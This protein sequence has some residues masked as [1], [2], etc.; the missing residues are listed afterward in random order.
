MITR[1]RILF[2]GAALGVLG[3]PALRAFVEA[4]S[5]ASPGD[6]AILN[7]A[8][9]LERAAVKAYTDAAGTGLLSA[10]VGTV[11]EGFKRD[12]EAHLGALMAAVQAA[13]AAPSTKAANLPYPPLKTEK[14]ILK[15]ARSVEE[16]AASTYLSVV[17]ELNDRNL[18]KVAASILGI[19]TTHVTQ[20]AAAL[21]DLPAYPGA[22]VR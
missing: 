17:P 1:G 22:F 12:H 16:K 21:G 18:A 2:S 14:D 9:E 3:L 6:I 13:G 15:F 8:I 10:R 5:A 11:A 7:A 19:E 4:A 20:L